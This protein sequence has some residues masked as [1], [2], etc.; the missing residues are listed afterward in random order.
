MV[1]ERAQRA[2]HRKKAL[3]IKKK[4]PFYNICKF[5]QHNQIKKCTANKNNSQQ[6]KKTSSSILQNNQI[7]KCTTN[8]M[9]QVTYVTMVPRV[10]NETLRPHGNHGYIHNLRCSP[11]WELRTASP[12]GRYGERYTH[13]T[14]LRGVQANF[15]QKA[16]TKPTLPG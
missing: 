8:I 2:A 11:S 3:Q 1:V 16:S 9:S 6:I 7:K 13:A 10:G 15:T 14:M 4:L 12:R 5:S